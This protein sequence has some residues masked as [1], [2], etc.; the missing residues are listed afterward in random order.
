[1]KKKANR[2]S[3]SQFEKIVKKNEIV[4]VPFEEGSDTNIEIIPTLPLDDMIEFVEVVVESCID[5]ESGDYTP[6][7][8]DFVVKRE[9]LTKYANFNMPQNVAKQYEFIYCS[10]VIDTVLMHIN[11]LQF[12]EIVTSIEKKIKF[13]LDNV[14]ITAAHDLATLTNQMTALIQQSDSMIKSVSSLSELDEEA[15]AKAVASSQV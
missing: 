4:K 6:Q 15:L 9:I 8:F 7:V 3:V 14:N 2:I 11:Q 13:M 10:N 12:R 1:M 5:S